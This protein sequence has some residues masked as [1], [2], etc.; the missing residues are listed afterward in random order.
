LSIGKGRKSVASR[1][2]RAGRSEA[3]GSYGS[4]YNAWE[5][6]GIWQKWEQE[7]CEYNPT[8]KLSAAQVVSL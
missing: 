7:T 2:I 1:H 6:N 3:P 8:R 4:Y 5:G